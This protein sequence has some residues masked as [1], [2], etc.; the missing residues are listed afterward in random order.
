M[1]LIS[2]YIN[3]LENGIEQNMNVSNEGFSLVK[4]N[5]EIVLKTQYFI[6]MELMILSGVFLK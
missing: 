1:L 4:D 3:E 6:K 2:L 5:G